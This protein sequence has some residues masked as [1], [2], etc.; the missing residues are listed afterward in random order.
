MSVSKDQASA[1]VRTVAQAHLASNCRQYRWAVYVAQRS[2]SSAFGFQVDLK[3]AEGKIVDENEDY[4][5]MKTSRTEFFVAAKESLSVVPQVGS[6]CRITPYARRL[7]DG[8]RLDAPIEENLGN[9]IVSKVYKLGEYR[10]YLPIDKASIVCFQFRDMINIIESERADDIPTVAQVL[11]DAG[12]LAEPVFFQDVLNE[13]DICDKPPTLRFKV[14]TSKHT[15]YVE[16][17]YDRAGDCFTV[18]VLNDDMSIKS[19]NDEVYIAID[20]PSEIGRIIIDAVDDGSW[21]IAPVEILKKAPARKA[22]AA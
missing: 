16:I 12:A 6:V 9:G 10:S 8:T 2:N 18:L 20:S 22:I 11:I 5:L 19:R 15:G 1:W 17:R 4:V 14:S 21:K 7:F 3:P 13:E